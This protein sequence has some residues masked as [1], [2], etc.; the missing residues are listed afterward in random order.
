MRS[1]FYLSAFV[2]LVSSCCPKADCAFPAFSAH[3]R[4]YSASDIDTMYFTGYAS[5]SNFSQVVE[6]RNMQNPYSTYDD[7][8]YTASFTGGYDVLIE[9]P[10]TQDTFKIYNFTF[11]ESACGKCIW[12]KTETFRVVDGATVNDTY[13]HGAAV[14]YK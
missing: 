3:L 14:L 9:I 8:T 13:Y 1:V 7:S 11:R 10:A 2:L 4:G 6:P 12:K 5:G